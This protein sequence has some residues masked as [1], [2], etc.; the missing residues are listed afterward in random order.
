[1]RKR[2]DTIFV[3]ALITLFA[4]TAFLL[5][6]IGAKQYRHV[7]DVMN[8]NF[9]VRTTSSYLSEKIRQNDTIDGVSVISLEGT[10]V[11]ALTTTEE[12]RRYLTY[13]YSYESSLRELVVTENSVFTLSS[14]QEILE[15]SGFLPELIQNNLLKTTIT[16]PDGSQEV[17]YFHIHCSTPVMD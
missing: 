7:T 4:A 5:V 2:I 8:D 14:G 10:P 12:G 17:L 11:L 3:L 15:L 9:L 1:M 6:L 16:N 13:I